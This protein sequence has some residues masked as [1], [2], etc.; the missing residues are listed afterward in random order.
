MQARCRTI[1]SFTLWAGAL[2]LG[3]EKEAT[4]PNDDPS[5]GTVSG[6]VVDAGDDFPVIGATISVTGTSLQVSSD[7]VGDY[8]LTGVPEGTQEIVASAFGYVP[9]SAS[10]AITGGEARVMDFRLDVEFRHGRP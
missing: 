6:T 1:V 3:C 7:G 2:G 10:V 8:T 4:P 9:S 5:T